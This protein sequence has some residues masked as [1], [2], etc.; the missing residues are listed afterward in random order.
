MTRVAIV[1]Y[2]IE[3]RSALPYWLEKSADVTVCDQNPSI[4]LPEGVKRQLGTS[5]LEGLDRFDV[6]VRTVGMHPQVILDK[7]PGVKD[8]ITT[9]LDELLAKANQADAE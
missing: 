2:G 4:E 3:G 7:N 5:Y 9:N 8:K 6:I 1:G